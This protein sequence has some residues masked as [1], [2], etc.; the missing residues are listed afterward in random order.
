LQ[1]KKEFNEKKPSGTNNNEQ[2]QVVHEV[3]GMCNNLSKTTATNTPNRCLLINFTIATDQPAATTTPTTGA[4]GEK[5]LASPL[6]SRITQL[7]HAATT[8][9]TKKKDQSKK[10]NQANDNGETTTTTTTTTTVLAT[11][12]VAA[13]NVTTES[14]TA[15]GGS[16]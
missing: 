16:A 8:T 9:I 4:T 10:Q 14:P 12:A 1:K 15:I 2:S 7:V 11:V 3:H 5:T 6:V 13:D